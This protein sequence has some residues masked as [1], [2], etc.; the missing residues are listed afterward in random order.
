MANTYNNNY[1][2]PVFSSAT[3]SARTISPTHIYNSIEE[4]STA[5]SGRPK[6]LD[7]AQ[8]NWG[9]M[10]LMGQPLNDYISWIEVF[11]EVVNC[12][13][14]LDAKIDMLSA[15]IAALENPQYTSITL[16]TNPSTINNL[17]SGSV[18]T[19]SANIMNGV[20]QTTWSL[21]PS[22][23]PHWD[24]TYDASTNIGTATLTANQETGSIAY[25]QTGSSSTSENGYVQF[26]ATWQAGTTYTPENLTVTV[27]N[28]S[29]SSS[30]VLKPKQVTGQTAGTWG[31]SLV[32]PPTGVTLD[33][34]NAGSSIT[35]TIKNTNTAARTVTLKLTN[36]S[37]Q[38]T[39]TDITV[40]AKSSAPVTTSYYLYVGT[41]K[42][43]SL[44]QANTV[45]SYPTEQTYTNNSGA[46]SHVFVL[47]N[48]NKT[49][50]FIEPSENSPITQAT[51]DTTTVS[52]YK[53]WET[54]VGVANSKS[55]K[56]QIS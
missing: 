35:G 53:I 14:D 24:F 1:S 27:K 21:S 15:R 48:N 45:T 51:V 46:K 37:S 28:N 44:S 11:N 19:V 12:L 6:L 5:I 23:H 16:S 25:S 38:F 18:I 55:V 36:N 2:N 33:Y 30:V 34:N 22:S 31:V 29:A 50:T 43:T 41:T 47:T 42:P 20:G 8:I 26:N 49:V 7:A 17:E 52:G 10:K 13:N 9:G 56:I 32:N 39:K 40:P 54:A 4:D 3:Q